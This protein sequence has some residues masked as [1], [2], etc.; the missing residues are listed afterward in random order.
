MGELIRRVREFSFK[1]IFFVLFIFVV[2]S[3]ILLVELSGVNAIRHQ[4]QLDLL[5]QNKIYTKAEA[6]GLLSEDTLLLRNSDDDASCLAY[7]EFVHI[8]SDMKVGYKDVDLSKESVPSF[9]GYSEVIVLLADL[10][11]MGNSIITLTEWVSNG[12]RAFFPLTLETNPYS[13]AIMQS[14]G[15]NDVSPDYYVVESIYVYENFMIGGG[16]AF[17][18]TNPFECAKTVVLSRERT[19]VF[20]TAG[21]TTEGVPLVWRTRYGSGVFVVDNIGIYEKAMRGFYAASYSLLSDVCVYPVINASVFYLDDFPSQ[22][23]SGNNEYIMRDY[24]TTVR[25]YYIN[26]WWPDM[27]NFSDKYGVKYTGLAIES[28]DDHTD[29]V[30]DAKPDTSTFINFGNMLLRKGGEL[31]YHG[32]NHQPLVIYSDYKGLYTYKTWKSDSAMKKAFDTLVDFC[33]GLF[34]GTK[35][36]LY[37]PPSNL[38]SDEGRDFLISNYPHIRTISGIYFEDAE[39]GDLDFGCTQEFDVDKNGVVDQPRVISG[40]ILDEFQNIVA[41]SELNMHFINSHFTHPDDALDAERGA[42]LGWE[43]MRRRF[44]NFLSWLY[45]SAPG[46]RNMTGTEASAAVQRFVACAPRTEVRGNNVEITIDNFYDEAQLFVRLNG[47]KP[48]SVRG[49]NLTHLTGDLYLLSATEKF[50]DIKLK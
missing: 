8:L 31:G 45:T 13:S 37:V 33:K 36:E 50:V 10:T 34:P 6:C 1:R 9:E 28:Y 18:I 2:I 20:A 40:F 48:D 44:D 42:T 16:R 49:G 41:I 4:R 30:T 38:L 47:R 3:A 24:H 15:V 35:F 17:T 14:I 43:E 7:G 23:P 19:E 22:I 46:L 39:Y 29:G 26:V 27:M 5:P 12:G 25:D 11:P 21:T 32:Y